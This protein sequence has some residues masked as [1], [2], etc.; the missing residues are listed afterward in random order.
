[1]YTLGSMFDNTGMKI[2]AIQ[3]LDHKFIVILLLSSWC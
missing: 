2:L 1:M 3:Y